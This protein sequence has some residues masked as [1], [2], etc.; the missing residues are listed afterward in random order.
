MIQGTGTGWGTQ[1]LVCI[2]GGNWAALGHGE[3]RRGRMGVSKTVLRG[4]DGEGRW[5]RQEAWTLSPPEL[6]AQACKG[7]WGIGFPRAVMDS[8]CLC[9][10]TLVWG[11]LQA[12]S[13]ELKLGCPFLP[14]TVSGA[15]KDPACG[16]IPSTHQTEAA[17]S[18][19]KVC[20]FSDKRSHICLHT[21]QIISLTFII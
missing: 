10:W 3:E 19:L 11:S 8:L 21:P 9:S 17:V 14:R 16:A 18:F 6:G 13:R 1:D 5:S 12:G 2:W 4:Q 20:L 15:G 7:R